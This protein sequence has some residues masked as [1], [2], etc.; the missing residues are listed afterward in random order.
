MGYTNSSNQERKFS[1]FG[2]SRYMWLS[3]DYHVISVFPPDASTVSSKLK[4]SV[5]V[6]L[7]IQA[8]QQW[9]FIQHQKII[10]SLYVPTYVPCDYHVISYDITHTRFYP[11]LWERRVEMSKAWPYQRLNSI[12]I[13]TSKELRHRKESG[14]PF[15][16]TTLAKI[17]PYFKT[18]LTHTV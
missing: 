14:P 13:T 11:E 18:S 17:M 15:L 12:P 6:F 16:S 1:T 8:G 9:V 10:W 7:G 3:C 2:Y 5:E 4:Y